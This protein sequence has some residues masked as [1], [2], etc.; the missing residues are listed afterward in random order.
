[1]PLAWEFVLNAPVPIVE[2]SKPAFIAIGSNIEPIINIPLAVTKLTALGAVIAISKVYQT[3]A[4]GPVKQADFLNLAV[5]ILTQLAA[6]PLRDQLRLFERQLGRTRSLDK[7]SPRTIDL[8]LCLLGNLVS[9][10]SDLLL[11][12]PD[13]E[14]YAHVIIPLAELAPSFPHPVTGHSLHEHAL[15]ILDS[16][17]APF[18]LRDDAALAIRKALQS[19]W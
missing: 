15:M 17:A 1:M 16:E 6:R 11:P 12:H 2:P 8:D 4:I 3:P 5:L 18:K 7:F 13:I 14:R 9:N 19:P 10:E